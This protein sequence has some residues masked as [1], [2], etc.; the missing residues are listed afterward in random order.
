MRNPA[1]RVSGQ[2]RV[3]TAVGCMFGSAA[4][5]LTVPL[6]PQRQACFQSHTL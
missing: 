1:G 5:R 6:S 3:Q 4:A 2:V